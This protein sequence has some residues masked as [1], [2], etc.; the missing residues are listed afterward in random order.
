[1]DRYKKWVAAGLTMFSAVALAACS[2]SN[3][4]SEAKSGSKP[5]VK[6][7]EYYNNTKKSS[8]TY[9]DGTL[10]VAEFNNSPFAGISSPSLQVNGEDQDVYSPGGVNLFNT[11]ANN[12]VV[13]GGLANLRLDK[14]K[15]TATITINPK[16]KWSNGMKVTAKDVEYPYEIIAAPDT[17]SQ[18]YSDDWKAID[19]MEAF[20]EGKA[21]TIS[22]IT[23]PKGEK[24]NVVV[25]H[26]NKFAPALKFGGNSFMW[27]GIEPYE[28]FKGVPIAKLG[29]SSQVRKNPIFA[30]PYKLSKQVTGESTSW[31]PNKYY[32][33]KKA[34]IQHITIQ[35][36][37]ENNFVSSLKSKQ[38][39]FAISGGISAQYPQLK[40]LKDYKEVGTMG[41]SFSY[42]AF[43]LGHFDT[44]KQ[45]NVSDKDAKMANPKLRKAMMYALDVAAL[46]KKF[47]NGLAWQ[48]NSLISPYFS[49]Y[50]NSKSPRYTLDL[51]KANKLL[52]QA[53]YKKKGK[54]RVQP[55]G[56]PL[57]IKF[58]AMSG[59]PSSEAQDNY[60]VQQWRKVGLNVS[61]TSGRPMEMNKFYSILEKPKQ[62]DMDVFEG[63]FSVNSEPTPT[64][65]FGAGAAFNM[66]H[67]ATEKN[68]E[69]LNN[70]NNSKAW[71]D[72][73][74]Q[75]QFKDWQTYMQNQ[76]AY[77]PTS[78]S[79]SWTPVNTRVKG[80]DARPT[81]TEFWSNLSLT[82]SNPD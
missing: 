71:N 44:K 62:S 58:G 16:A 76:A 26:Y 34:Q 33:G 20:H 47:N 8:S 80:Y 25:I 40:Q 50:Y 9:N 23:M 77:V 70:M 10:K 39:D 27:S 82:N 72:K 15:M 24:G 52:D 61:F 59:T 11:D 14:D 63:A 29:E 37:N 21:K 36:V 43:N 51:D 32:Y 74:R 57:T 66:A 75:K 1:M 2:N 65:I 81:A 17:T 22:G 78:M 54:W 56:Q 12:K 42:L 68:T 45:V 38:Y 4:N 41:T 55:N 73:Y 53:G 31:V 48:P 7:A 13:D 49:T 5:S 60:Y 18:Q 6:M 64:G 30:G 69:L 19:G 46:R 67:F 35:V 79:L 3:N 28:Y